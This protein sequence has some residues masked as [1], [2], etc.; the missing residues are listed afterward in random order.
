MKYE[1]FIKVIGK[2]IDLA[3]YDTRFK[4]SPY[5]KNENE[6]WLY[7]KDD[8]ELSVFDT[9]NTKK[10]ITG[11]EFNGKIYKTLKKMREDFTGGR[12][13]YCKI[14]EYKNFRKGLLVKEEYLLDEEYLKLYLT[15]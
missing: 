3:L 7:K 2:Y 1:D 9:N 4:K 13:D 11:Y 8:K 14:A 12:N 10:I 5:Y 6:L 15:V